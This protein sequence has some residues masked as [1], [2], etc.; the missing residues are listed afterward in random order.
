[1]RVMGNVQRG[2]GSLPRHLTATFREKRGE[3]QEEWNTWV[4]K[5]EGNV[6]EQGSII[7]RGRDPE[8]G[9]NTN[10]RSLRNLRIS[11]THAWVASNPRVQR[12]KC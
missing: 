10:C 2:G 6:T 8:G 3:L 5:L 12:A 1:M 4:S 7:K 11:S 9:K